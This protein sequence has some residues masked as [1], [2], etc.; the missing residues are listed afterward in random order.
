M[1][2]NLEAYFLGKVTC[3]WKES[4]EISFFPSLKD[5]TIK[6]ETKQHFILKHIFPMASHLPLNWVMAYDIDPVKT[7]NEKKYLLSKIVDE[8]WIVFFEHDPIR[9]ACKVKYNGKQ[10]N[11]KETV[12]IS[13]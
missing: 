1:R 5:A 13:G 2:T 12:V 8:D 4:H 10:Y 3:H 7:I 11:L 6:N 9:Q